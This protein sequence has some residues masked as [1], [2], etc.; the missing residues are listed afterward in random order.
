MTAS[1]SNAVN[2]GWVQVLRSLQPV[3]TL[4]RGRYNTPSHILLRLKKLSPDHP[5]HRNI[6]WADLRVFVPG[7]WDVG[8]D[9]IST[10]M[11][12]LGYYRGVDRLR[13][14][15]NKEIRDLRLEMCQYFL[16]KWSDPQDWLD[17]VIAFSDEA[18]FN[19]VNRGIRHVTIHQLEDPASF[20]RLRHRGE[21]IMFWGIVCGRWKGPCF[22][23]PT[24]WTVNS[25]T[26]EDFV[27]PRVQGFV[28]QLRDLRPDLDIHF[29]HDG[30]A[31]HTSYQTTDNLDGMSFP[32]VPWASHSPDLNPIENLWAYMKL[33]IDDRY[34]TEDLTRQELIRVVKEAWEAIPEEELEKL[35][36]GMPDRLQTCIDNQGY[37]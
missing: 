19:N 20:V 17:G 14:K 28:E 7:F 16:N 31:V 8:I 10:A 24:D 36:L 5:S 35:A 30:S 26:Y 3:Q 27:L 12:D 15:T 4:R 9:A 2:D 32:V 33:W 1:V 34:V 18:F 23:F 21:G 29:M 6:A 22:V 13:I 11:L 37:P 25:D